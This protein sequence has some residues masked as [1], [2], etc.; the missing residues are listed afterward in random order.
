VTISGGWWHSK[1]LVNWRFIK[2]DVSPHQ[3]PKEDMCAPAHCRSRRLYLFQSTFGRRPIWSPT[4][5][6]GRL[7]SSIPAPSSARAQG[8]GIPHLPHENTDRWFM[9][10]GSSSIPSTA[11]K[12]DHEQAHL[13]R[14]SSEL[15]KLHPDDNGWERFGP[16][17]TGTITPSWKAMDD[18]YRA[19][20][21]LQYGRLGRNTSLCNGT[22]WATALG[23]S[24]RAEH[25]SPTTG[26]FVTGG[27]ATVSQDNWHYWNTGT[28]WW[29]VISTSSD[30]SQCSRRR[31]DRRADVREHALSRLPTFPSDEK[32]AK[33]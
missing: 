19:N 14:N 25:P 27:Q 3:W 26:G 32:V 12:L 8:V 31:F 5:Q 10:F 20:Y 2:P 9:Y 33:G 22:T 23:R 13:L 29:A 1:D 6:T 24:V 4:R 11:S 17:H 16:N 28:P 7:N 30:A 18:K 15:F 21:Y